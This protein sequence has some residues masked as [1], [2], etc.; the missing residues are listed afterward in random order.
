MILRNGKA[1]DTLIEVMFAIT[2][3]SLVIVSSLSIMN[4]G[5]ATA[6]RSLEI[7]LVRVQMDAQAESLRYIHDSYIAAYPN[8]VTGDPSG[9]WL[10]VTANQVA[11]AT[12][13]G[14]CEP[15]GQAFIINPLTEKVQPRSAIISSVQ[16]FAQIRQLPSFSSEGLW[17]EAIKLNAANKY[18]DFHIRACWSS[19]GLNAPM[20]L[21][22]IVR[23]YEP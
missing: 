11:Q 1:G 16:T 19:Q 13:F 8:P 7:T 12:N 17:V 14:N 22:T 6:Q 20:T 5:V 2:V 9:E 3:F 10:N 4:S 23:L 21:G 15:P 18:I